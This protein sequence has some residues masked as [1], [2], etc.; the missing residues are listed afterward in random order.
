MKIRNVIRKRGVKYYNQT[1]IKLVKIQIRIHEPRTC[2]L[3]FP[4][5]KNASQ[6]FNILKIWSRM[7]SKDIARCL[8]LI[9]CHFLAF[10]TILHPIIVAMEFYLP[11]LATVRLR[12]EVLCELWS[13]CLAVRGDI[14]VKNKQGEV[15]KI[16]FTYLQTATAT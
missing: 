15:T 5:T 13:I 1:D 2:R 3:K 16:M 12:I 10:P 14:V 7:K 4:R 8:R 9:A 6:N 11:E